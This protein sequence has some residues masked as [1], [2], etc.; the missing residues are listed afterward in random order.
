MQVTEQAE[1]EF[2]FSDD[3]YDDDVVDERSEDT[4]KVLIVD[5]DPEIHSVTQLALSDVIVF[6]RSLEYLHA[7]SGQDACQLIASR[8]DIVLVLL[9]VVMVTD[10]AGLNVVKYIRD[11]LCR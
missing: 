11:D 7:Y 6:G 2:L 3:F 1:E 4:W 9:D 5:D 8:D 10:D